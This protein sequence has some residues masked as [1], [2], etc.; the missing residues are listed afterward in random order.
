M[1]TARHEHDAPNHHVQSSIT[2]LLRNHWLSS[3][4]ESNVRSNYTIK[5]F[6]DAR[7]CNVTSLSAVSHNRIQFIQVAAGFN[8]DRFITIVGPGRANQR[9]TKAIGTVDIHYLL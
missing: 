4:S 9:T 6:I 1:V 5:T 2:D 7:H 3:E 8:L